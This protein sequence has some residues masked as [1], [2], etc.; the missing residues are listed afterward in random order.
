MTSKITS[1]LL[2]LMSAVMLGLIWKL[3]HTRAVVR[4]LGFQQDSLEAVHDSTKKVLIGDIAFWTRRAVQIRIQ[5]YSVDKALQ[6][7][8]RAKAALAVQVAR[9]RDSASAPVKEVEGVRSATFS[10]DVPPYHVRSVVTLPAPPATGTAHFDIA[11]DP[12]RL[13]VRV[14]C[15]V[16][17]NRAEI[18]PAYVNVQGPEWAT[19]QLGSVFYEQ[20]VCNPP[21]TINTQRAST[22]KAF[23]TGAAAGV[24]VVSAKDLLME[25]LKS[26]R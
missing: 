12:L 17:P 18:R 3:N 2:I 26:L 1:G 6:Q 10:H 8:T 16:P 7:E 5:R 23:F 21:V 15:A 20:S 4:Q 13:E 24:L 11:L 25:L 9:L 22:V 19:V 14:G